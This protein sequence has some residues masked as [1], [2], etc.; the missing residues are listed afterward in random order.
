M[1]I[2]TCICIPQ[3]IAVICMHLHGYVGVH[4]TGKVNVLSSDWRASDGMT[5]SISA[6]GMTT[7]YRQSRPSM[8]TPYLGVTASPPTQDVYRS[9]SV[10]E[11]T[12][13]N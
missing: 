10:N 4:Y 11:E 7:N 5:L 1:T 8:F 3:G 12:G 2:C 13:M 9:A 6:I